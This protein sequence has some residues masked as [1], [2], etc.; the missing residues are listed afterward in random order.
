MSVV[1]PTCEN[2]TAGNNSRAA[3]SELMEK[4]FMGFLGFSFGA[5]PADICHTRAARRVLAKARSKAGGRKR[6]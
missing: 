5:V 6:H 4:N 1:E 2:A 3:A